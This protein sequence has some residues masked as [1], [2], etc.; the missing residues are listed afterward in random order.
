MNRVPFDLERAKNGDP[1][2]IGKR[3]TMERKLIGVLPD[4]RVAHYCKNDRMD[5]LALMPDSDWEMFPPERWV[6]VHPSLIYP[7]KE[8]AQRDLEDK[9]ITNQGFI[10]AKLEN[11]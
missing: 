8:A 10:I 7:T 4:G 9:K 6:I 1:F 2:F 11:Q 5:L 3:G